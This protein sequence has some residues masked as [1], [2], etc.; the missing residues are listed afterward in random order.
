ME[1]GTK[2]YEMLFEETTH[3]ELMRACTVMATEDGV[4]FTVTGIVRYSGPRA[5][6]V[7]YDQ[8]GVPKPSTGGA[9]LF[10]TEVPD[11]YTDEDVVE[12]M[13][14][15]IV[16]GDDQRVKFSRLFPGGIVHTY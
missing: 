7:K 1:V 15:I 3:E 13:R 11:D 5:V 8:L 12:L 14:E 9:D 6:R 2:I 10:V 4:P 16:L